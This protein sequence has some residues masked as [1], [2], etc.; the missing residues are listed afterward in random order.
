MTGEIARRPGLDTDREFLYQLLRSALG[1]YVEATYGP[2]D[3]DWQR[4]HFV[5]TTVPR[6]HEIVEFRGIP[7]GCLLIEERPDS[8]ELHRILIVPE[9]QSRGIGAS[10]MDEILFAAAQQNKRVRLQVFRVNQRGIRFY[11]R[12]GFRPV[13]ETATHVVMEHVV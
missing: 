9:H 11:Q 12:L 5:A 4:G 1:P 7:I 10:L 6:A 2:W 8:V 13:D 3:E